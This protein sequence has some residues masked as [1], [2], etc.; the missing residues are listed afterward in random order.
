LKEVNFIALLDNKNQVIGFAIIHRMIFEGK[1]ILHIRQA[2]MMQQS[3]GYAGIMARYLADNYATGIYEANIRK[4]NKVLMKF[5]LVKEDLLEFIDAVL[6]YNSNYYSGLR[7]KKVML[8]LFL[9]HQKKNHPSKKLFSQFG[10]RNFEAES[11]IPFFSH[12]Q[13]HR[14]L[15]AKQDDNY[16]HEEL[17][18]LHIKPFKI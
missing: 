3:Q 13:L 11:I 6:N 1:N 7:G 16:C 12:V 17:S 9:E 10:Q 2:A 5:K 18:Y 15:I 14:D 8:D 4:A